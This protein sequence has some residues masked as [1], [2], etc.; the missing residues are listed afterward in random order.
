M[1]DCKLPKEKCQAL[2]DQMILALDGNLSNHEEKQLLSEIDKHP[3]CFEKM[4]IEKSFRDFL[5]NKI[6]RKEVPI[7]LVSSIKTKVAELSYQING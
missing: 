1:S 6:T 5:C 7:E 3:C 4:N 2:F